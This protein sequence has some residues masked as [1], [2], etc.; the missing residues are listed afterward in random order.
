M[1]A[2]IPTMIWTADEVAAAQ[3]QLDTVAVATVVSFFVPLLVSLI[4]KRTASNGLKSVVNILAT[5]VVAV[6]SLWQV[7]GPGVEISLVLV[8]NTFL[9]SLVASLV[10]YKGLWKPTGVTATIEQKSA[11]FGV[12]SPPAVQTEEG[13]VEEMIK[14]RGL[15]EDYLANLDADP[16]PEE[17]D[18][19]DEEELNER[20]LVVY[21]DAKK[22]DTPGVN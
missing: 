9:G 7:P 17:V 18:P 16:E 3:D 2:I 1:Q 21:D 6:I 5:A 10:A 11:R 12:G 13:Q 8:V 20:L 19:V 15:G 14:E 22:R 4:T